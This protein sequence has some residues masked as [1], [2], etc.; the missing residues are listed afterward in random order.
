MSWTACVLLLGVVFVLCGLAICRAAGAITEQEIQPLDPE[1]RIVPIRPQVNR[2]PWKDAAHTIVLSAEQQAELLRIHRE[3]Y[4]EQC[5]WPEMPLL[6]FFR[7][8]EDH[9][10]PDK[11][12]EVEVLFAQREYLRSLARSFEL[13]WLSYAL[14]TSERKEQL[15]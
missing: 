1:P 12:L 14:A 8:V 6:A 9:Q 2:T 4:V 11:P 3:K 15:T 13:D 5:V 7:A 10:R